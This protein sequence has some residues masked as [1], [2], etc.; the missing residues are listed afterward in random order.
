MNR[1]VNASDETVIE[2]GRSEHST[3]GSN[4]ALF[5][6]THRPMT[7]DD[8]LKRIRRLDFTTL[9]QVHDQFY[10]V[11]YRYVR[12]RLDDETTSEDIASEV[13]MRLLDALHKESGPT[14]D[15]RAWLMGTA[16]NLINDHLRQRYSRKVEPIENDDAILSPG[17]L[18]ETL[19]AKFQNQQLR[20]AIGKLTPEQQDVLALRF[21]EDYSLVQT[22]AQMKKSVNAIKALQFRAIESLKRLLDEPQQ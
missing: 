9:A 8:L 22:A 18:E 21:V 16:S 6:F 14:K 5:P 12:Y 4:H 7:T 15:V 13:F 10:P 20:H 17:S 3:I 2:G 11:V 1:A 19:D